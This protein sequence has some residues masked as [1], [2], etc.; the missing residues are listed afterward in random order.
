VDKKSLLSAF[1]TAILI[2][3]LVLASAMRFGTVQ[4]STEV[5]GIISSN[6]TFTKANSPYVFTGP[7]VVN[8]DAMLTIEAGVS[9]DL[10]G[11]YLE[12]SGTL[13]AK[14]SSV[15]WIYFNSG[16]INF[17]STSTTSCIIEN[18]ILNWI[19]VSISSSVKINSTYIKG[20]QAKNV[21]NIYGGAP[22][23]TNNT[24]TGG[25]D[26]VTIVSISG[27]SPTI[28]NNNII[29]HVDN[30]LYPNP[31]SDMNRFGT[32]YG[33]YAENVNGAYITDNQ[34]FRAFRTESIRV[35]SGSATVEGN[36]ESLY[37]PVSTPPPTPNP[38]PPISPTPTLPPYPPTSPT[39]TPTPT[40]TPYQE[41]QQTEQLEIII[42]AAIAA[43]II[44]AGLGL[45][46]YLVKRK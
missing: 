19:D 31:P 21:I 2:G 30:G 24:L 11:N 43:A 18:A 14:G 35:V 22:I 27:G 40:I 39:P 36:S 45:L 46:I 13:I 6:V 20:A 4:A 23:I 1:L 44:G 8:A 42:G 33:V 3:G 7:V 29:A 9:I 28:S 16:S 12:V 15:D 32:E 34:F 17:A 10:D 38:T 25:V 37:N 26:S 41:P 5:I